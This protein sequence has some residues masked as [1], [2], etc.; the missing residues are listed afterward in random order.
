MLHILSKR[1]AFLVCKKT[2]KIPFEIYV[3]GFELLVSSIIET[4]A[5]ILIGGLIG[6]FV[7]TIL[8]II[9]FSSIRFFSGGYHANSYLKCFVVTMISYILILLMT[10]ILSE[11]SY[12]IIVLIALMIFVLSLILFIK[13]CPVYSNGKTI[14]N[15]TMQKKLSVIAL[16]I[17]IILSVALFSIHQN[18]MLII[19]LLTIFTVDAMIIIEKLKQGVEKNEKNK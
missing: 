16:C 9:S 12:S 4:G 2:D 13:I 15:P 1:I 6:K 10:N 8:F 5:L 11:L 19:V 7:E 3:Y 18:Y 17:N 14:F